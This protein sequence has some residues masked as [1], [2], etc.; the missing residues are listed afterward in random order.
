MIWGLVFERV[1]E[2]VVGKGEDTRREHAWRPNDPFI[3]ALSGGKRRLWILDFHVLAFS[4]PLW[5]STASSCSHLTFSQLIPPNSVVVDNET[6]ERKKN[7]SRDFCIKNP[8][9]SSSGSGLRPF[10]AGIFNVDATFPPLSKSHGGGGGE[11]ERTVGMDD[12]VVE[13]KREPWN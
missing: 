1:E 11:C 3:L 10:R 6:Q 7:D 4:H 2:V 9:L 12:E 5:S 13:R 8:G